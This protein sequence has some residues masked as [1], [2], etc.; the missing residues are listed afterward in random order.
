MV[1]QAL[2]RYYDLLAADPDC[3]IAREG[4]SSANV[5]A[6]LVLNPQGELV[7]IVPQVELHQAGKR[8]IEGYRKMIVPEQIKRSGQTPPP[9]FL[10][11]NPAYVLGISKED[12]DKPEYA[13]KRFQAFR[14]FHLRLFAGVNCPEAATISA[15]LRAHDPRKAREHPLILSQLD[16]LLG[17]GNLVFQLEGSVQFAHEVS[18]IRRV[19][20]AHRRSGVGEE[21][22]CLVTGE[23]TRI[24][25]LHPAIQ[26]VRGA[27]SSGAT[28]VGFNAPAYESYNRAKG[29]GL[30]APTG[31][32]AAF[33]YTTVL[34]YLLS[35]ESDTPK[36]FLGDTTVVYWAESVSRDYR[37]LFAALFDPSW[38]EVQ[39]VDSGRDQ[40]ASQRLREI[41]ARIRNGDPLDAQNLL[42]GLEPDTSFY[43]LGLAPNAA[44]ISVRFFLCN[45]FRQFVERIMAHY[46]DLE[47]VSQFANQ[48]G[49]IP[50]RS[51]VN[52]TV[53]P[54]ASKQEPAPL[55]GGA[56]LRAVLNDTPYPAALYYAILNRVRADMD[57]AQK[58]ISKINQVRA[59]IIKAYLSRKFRNQSAS[60]IQETLCMALNEQSTHPA[61]L[62]G[63]LFAVL[64]KAQTDALGDVN[65]TIKD[66]YFTTACANPASVFPVLLRLSQHHIAKAEFGYVSDR[67]IQEILGM[68]Q[69]DK[70]PIPRHLSL[71]EQG[72]FIL[73]YYHQ[74]A[75]IFIP[76]KNGQGGST[77]TN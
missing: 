1:L 7:G 73:G 67:R 70:N 35:R 20:E 34:K 74:R 11:D 9:N 23:W 10:C 19:W 26:G 22:Q 68:F 64:E 14:E 24:A 28:L 51:I 25:R 3:T 58:K 40:E 18:A 5:N 29:Q 33:A 12:A 72:V 53:S 76:R 62:L 47:I 71:D 50:L 31:E 37:D 59:A 36:F 42:V 41:A 45:P 60:P 8:T 17:G 48:S 54:K 52:E 65:A 21:G 39:S 61:Y 75:A 63:R 55:L 57:D 6:A 32:R 77:D 38:T 44:R 15:F 2:T 13:L 49:R 30:N 4:Y 66:R 56:V 16:L 46:A 27:Q 43:V 69:M